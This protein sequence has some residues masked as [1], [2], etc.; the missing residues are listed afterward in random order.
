MWH[1][2]QSWSGTKQRHSP[3]QFLNGSPGTLLATQ[4]GNK[5]FEGVDYTKDTVNLLKNPPQVRRFWVDTS[6]Y[7]H[8]VWFVSIVKAHRSSKNFHASARCRSIVQNVVV[9]F[10]LFFHDCLLFKNYEVRH[11]TEFPHI[12]IHFA[13]SI[14][15]RRLLGL[16]SCSWAGPLGG[17][18]S[19]EL[20]GRNNSWKMGRS[21]K[22]KDQCRRSANG[23]GSSPLSS[24][25]T[26]KLDHELIEHAC[27]CTTTNTS[28]MSRTLTG[29]SV[30]RKFMEPGGVQHPTFSKQYVQTLKEL[31]SVQNLYGPI[32]IEYNPY[33]H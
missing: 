20:P 15:T 26:R 19:T 2:R 25:A 6:V 13:S 8:K 33:N 1:N 12:T 14:F 22:W 24:P 29:S 10:N 27:F 31:G 7:K 28:L 11:F 23:R 9:T 16:I 5:Y 21:W 4:V 30:F 18:K 32:R 3:E 17:F